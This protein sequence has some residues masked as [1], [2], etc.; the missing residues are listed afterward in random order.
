[1]PQTLVTTPTAL[2]KDYSLLNIKFAWFVVFHGLPWSLTIL[3]FK[4]GLLMCLFKVLQYSLISSTSERKISESVEEGI[5]VIVDN[6]HIDDKKPET[7]QKGIMLAALV[8]DIC[9]C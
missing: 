1:M 3:E 6:L 4:R 8:V 2:T 5:E 7:Q 9:W